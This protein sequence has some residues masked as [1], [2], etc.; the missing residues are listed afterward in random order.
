MLLILVSKRSCAQGTSETR[1]V[2][3]VH[4]S[5]PPTL[6]PVVPLA[7]DI[8][9]ARWGKNN[10]L[11]FTQALKEFYRDANFE[12]FFASHQVMY[13]LAESRFSVVL[14]GLN[15]DWYKN[16]YGEAPKGKFNVVLG[17]KLPASTT[18]AFM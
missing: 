3:H 17:M 18:S 4:L 13:Q 9:D 11:S 16:F 1:L 10:A 15:L 7:D 14:E 12:R 6:S 2:P 5:P 8:P